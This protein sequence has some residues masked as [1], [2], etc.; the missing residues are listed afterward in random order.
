MDM[1][2]RVARAIDPDVW[3]GEGDYPAMKARIESRRAV[4]LM[5][6]RAAIEAMRDPTPEIY[7]ALTKAGMNA[8]PRDEIWPTDC[9]A[10]A[11]WRAGINAAL[12]A[13]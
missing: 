1:L 9:S 13:T 8:S 5:N 4:S 3:E 6:A 7:R 11:I 2:E 12:T 10:G